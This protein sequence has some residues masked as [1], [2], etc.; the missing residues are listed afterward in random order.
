MK[1]I[2]ISKKLGPLV[3]A[4]SVESEEAAKTLIISAAKAICYSDSIGFRSNPSKEEIEGV[5]ALMKGI[6]PRD[7]IEALY[8]AQIVAAHMLGMRKLAD[9][10]IDDQSF[11]LKLLSFST[12]AMQLLEKKRNMEIQDI[13]VKD[14]P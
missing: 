3:E 10:H 2:T 7:T 9:E 11:G 4:F 13:L 1:D 8:A 5:W 14:Q 6:K 12:H